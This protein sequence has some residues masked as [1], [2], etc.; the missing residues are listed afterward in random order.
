MFIVVIH[1]TTYLK[2]VR[3]LKTEKSSA[4]DVAAGQVWEHRKQKTKVTV[5]SIN[6][7]GKTALLVDEAGNERDMTFS[8]LKK[9]Y[10]LTEETAAKKSKPRKETEAKKE[11]KSKAKAKDKG[12]EFEKP[13]KIF[14]D[15]VSLM[16]KHNK[17][18]VDALLSVIIVF[19][20][21]NYDS[22]YTEKQRSY[23][24]INNQVGLMPKASDNEPIYMFSLAGDDDPVD[25]R[26][27]N[28]EI[29][30]AYVEI[31]EED[32]ELPDYSE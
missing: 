2:E 12:A 1:I 7:K 26:L 21:D 29:E 3:T 10:K 24:V 28:Y 32:E 13:H 20:A 18:D 15:V 19:S 31:G 6:A 25:Y 8:N 22:K 9:S 5:E 14:E 16:K 4:V 17:K 11:T 23:R 30:T 27:Y